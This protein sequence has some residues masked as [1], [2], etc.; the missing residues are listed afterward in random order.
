MIGLKIIKHSVCKLVNKNDQMLLIHGRIG[1]R[2]LRLK[3]T[4]NILVTLFRDHSQTESF[5][6]RDQIHGKIY[7]DFLVQVILDKY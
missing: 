1:Y 7:G 5:N 4:G 2:A 3:I 6:L